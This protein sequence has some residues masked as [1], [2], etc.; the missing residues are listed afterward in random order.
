M[1]MGRDETKIAH[2]EF[3]QSLSGF[4]LFG[5]EMSLFLKT[6]PSLSVSEEKESLGVS[7]GKNDW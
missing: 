4:S 1:Q 6:L 5:D 7:K 2:T 3:L